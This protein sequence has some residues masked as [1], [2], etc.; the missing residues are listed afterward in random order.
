[1]TTLDFC[2]D[3]AC[4]FAWITSRWT[5]EVEQH[6]DIDVRFRGM[7]LCLHNEGNELPGWYRELVDK[8]MGPV[9]WPPR[10]LRSTGA[11]C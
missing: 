2:S 6:R 3:P 8:S 5:L 4:P 10:L 7:S 11:R 1:M 9:R